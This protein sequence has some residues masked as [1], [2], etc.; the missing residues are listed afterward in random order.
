MGHI[1][2]E[3][4]ERRKEESEGKLTVQLDADEMT[5]QAGEGEE[6][7]GLDGDLGKVKMDRE[8]NFSP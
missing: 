1:H 7:A 2:D 3:G 4:R 5:A 6:A 8:D